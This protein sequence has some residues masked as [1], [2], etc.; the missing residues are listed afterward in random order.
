MTAERARRNSLTLTTI[1]LGEWIPRVT[2]SF[3]NPRHLQPLVDLFDRVEHEPIRACISVPPRHSKTE[4]TLHGIAR[5]LQR[6]PDWTIAYVSYSADI[7]RSKSRLIRDYALRAGVALRDDT[8]ALNEWRTPQ[9]GGVI[10]AGIGG[11]LTGFGVRLLVVDDPHKNRQEADSALIRERIYNWF[12]STGLT[13][14]EPGGSVIV[15]HT[16]W[17]NDDLIGRLGR[18]KEVKWSVT[19]LPAINAKGEAL[20]PERWPLSELRSKE[21]DVGPYD[22]ESLFQQNPTVRK[23]RIYALF[24]RPKHVVS[25]ASILA[26]FRSYDGRWLFRRIIVAIDWGFS[27][28]CAMLVIGETGTGDLYVIDELYER[29]VL[30][31]DQGWLKR[32]KDL[33]TEYRPERFVADPSESGYIMQLRKSLNGSPIVV[34]A[35]NEISLGITRVQTKLNGP[36]LFVSDHCVNTI[37]EIE[38]YAYAVGPFGPTETPQAGNDHAMDALRYGVMALH[39]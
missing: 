39:R 20:W 33:R 10:A 11:P 32:A 15:V 3:S 31:D 24:D 35:E 27:D 16:R 9:G 12:T 38:T 2:P 17:N 18:D 13:R 14:V 6:H 21:R 7:A 19:S 37:R 26:K 34:G 5:L 25:R 4:T 29:Q 36:K 22:W 8:T 23:G 28:P 1:S 30:V